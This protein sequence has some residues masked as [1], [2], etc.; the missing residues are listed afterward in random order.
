MSDFR[1]LTAEPSTHTQA[2]F[3]EK[4]QQLAGEQ[5]DLMEHSFFPDWLA[6][7]NRAIAINAFPVVLFISLVVATVLFVVFFHF[8]FGIEPRFT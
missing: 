1:D 8:F 6:P 2:E 5:R 3:V 7:L 4:L